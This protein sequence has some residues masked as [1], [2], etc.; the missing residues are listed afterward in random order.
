MTPA[1]DDITDYDISP[2]G[3]MIAY[4]S[5]NQ[6]WVYNRA[7]DD[8]VELVSSA[9]PIR[10]P[11]FSPD[12]TRIVYAVDTVENSR[13][14]GI[15]MAAV[16]EPENNMLILGN[17][18]T[19]SDVVSPPFYREP[20]WAPNINALLVKAS[21]SETTSLSV[22]DVNT[23]EVV[24][25]GQYDDGFWLRDGRVL[26][27]GTGIGIGTPQA[28]E[29]VILDPNTQQEPIPLFTIPTDMVIEQLI[30]I[31]QLELRLIF[32][33]NAFGPSPLFVVR[34]PLDGLS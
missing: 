8:L 32:R 24:P 17:G 18:A 33:R 7:D 20:Q 29:V 26:A 22:L 15:W 21:G 27:W 25:L 4:V 3:Q 13:N 14:G 12:G 9:E 23:L 11:R 5:P 10:S 34:V 1:I 19:G 16:A 30:Q 6:L 31:A 2:D 28:S